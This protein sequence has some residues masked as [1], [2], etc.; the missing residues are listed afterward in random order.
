MSAADE[1]SQPQ[2]GDRQSRPGKGE[3]RADLTE[4]VKGQIGIIPHLH[5]QKQIENDTERKLHRRND[6]TAH[7]TAQ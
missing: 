3:I 4:N 1:V 6:D 7:K 5:T 2:S